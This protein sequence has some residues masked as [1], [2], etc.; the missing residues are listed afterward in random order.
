MSVTAQISTGVPKLDELLGGGLRRGGLHLFVGEP[1]AGKTVLAHQIGVH[2]AREGRSVL[3][4]T[5]MV[6]AHQTLLSQVRNFRFYDP[7]V[8]ADRFYYASL[9]G[10]FF[11]DGFAGVEAEVSRLLRERAAD[12]VM[13]DGLHGLKSMAAHREGY[14][15]FLTFMQGQCASTGVTA[16]LI[17]N[18][19]Q[20]D[21]GDPMYTVSDGIVVLETEES[22]RRRVRTIEVRKLR[23]ASHLT[24]THALEITSAGIEVFPRPESL[25]AQRGMPA[26]PAA[27]ERVGFGIEGLDGMLHG[28]LS[29]ASVTLLTG[30][31][32]S[33]KTLLALAFLGHGFAAGQRGLFIGFHETPDRL[34]EKAEG[35]GLPLGPRVEEGLCEVRWYPSADLQP[36]RVAY[37]ILHALE[38]TQHRRVVI[39]SADDLVNGLM[40][41]ERA[42]PF[43]NAL[44]ALLRAH[45]VSVIMTQELHQITTSDLT[46]PLPEVS[47]AVD[48]ILMLRSIELHS[49]FRRIIW[50]LKVRDQAY[51]P[52][53]RELTIRS[54]GIE[55][56]GVVR[57]SGLLTGSPRIID[58]GDAPG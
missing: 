11:G 54:S 4:L 5:A 8:M 26:A 21:H 45:Q 37:D 34:H 22:R 42:V 27:T 18:R 40:P 13:L 3:Y 39:D 20:A 57:A 49:A 41:R 46:L 7:A 32:G 35:V 1:G 10:P 19:D 55:I 30:T 28:G 43:L 58:A 9:A 38:G 12:L 14:H 52:T 33:G 56:G 6:E 51:D 48:N 29:P 25:V 53:L 50:I 36:D 23:G 31:P 47:A 16:V 17:S 24:G 2:H 44:A 15:R